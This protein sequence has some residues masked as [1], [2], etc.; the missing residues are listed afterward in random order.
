M[1]VIEQ[2][3]PSGTYDVGDTV[4][5][6]YDRVVPITIDMSERYRLIDLQSGLDKDP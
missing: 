3:D 5:T 2:H 6:G 1:I 4:D